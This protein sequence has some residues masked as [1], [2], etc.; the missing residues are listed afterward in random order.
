MQ[1]L[2][3]L[4]DREKCPE[5]LRD[6]AWRDYRS[7]YT[8]WKPFLLPVQRGAVSAVAVSP[9]G[10]TL[11]SATGGAE[12]CI[13]FWDLERREEIGTLPS[14]GRHQLYRLQPRWHAA[15]FGRR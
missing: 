4:E 14:Q 5:D 3:E 13:K 1:A 2:V 11:A 9:D 7:L 10:K 12:A 8:E 15:G 6:F